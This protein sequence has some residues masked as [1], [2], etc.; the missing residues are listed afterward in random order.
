M[1]Q[2]AESSVAL[3]SPYARAE[4][5]IRVRRMTGLPR[6]TFCDCEGLTADAIY[7]WERVRRGGLNAKGAQKV[8]QRLAEF[9][10]VCTVHWLM[11]GVG[12]EPFLENTYQAVVGSSLSQA[13][14]E[15]QIVRELAVF[16]SLP[17][18]VDWIVP[19]EAMAPEYRAGDYVAGV[20]V[21]DLSQAI[22]LVCIVQ[23]SQG[24]LM[25]RKVREGSEP[26]RFMLLPTMDA[27]AYPIVPNAELKM[28]APVLWRRR[29]A[30]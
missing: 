22:G 7:R 2:A 14:E 19:D 20:K 26:N 17:N 13:T 12:V 29:Q 25:L 9:G 5:L 10:V 4:R 18:S 8:I 23:S 3:N 15:A 30:L 16:R 27:P 6:H 21:A 24:E 11:E 28:A 1:S